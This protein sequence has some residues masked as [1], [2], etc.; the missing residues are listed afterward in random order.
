MVKGRLVSRFSLGT[1]RERRWGDEKGERGGE[2][3]M[4]LLGFNQYGIWP[5]DDWKTNLIW[6][7]IVSHSSHRLSFWWICQAPICHQIHITV[8]VGFL[9]LI[10]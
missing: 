7:A 6:E 9:H 1:V 2:H 8:N 3:L 10:A 5:G 4:R